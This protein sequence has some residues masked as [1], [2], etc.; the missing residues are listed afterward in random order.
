METKI[1]NYHKF[2]IS[3]FIKFLLLP[4]V[5]TTLQ[6]GSALASTYNELNYADNVVSYSQGYGVGP[7]YSNTL[8]AL[9]EEDGAYVSLGNTG[10]LIVEFTDNVLVGDGTAAWDLAILDVGA[11]DDIHVYIST[12][13]SSWLYIGYGSID[14][15]QH[16]NIDSAQDFDAGALYKYVKIVDNGLEVTTGY[17]SAGYDVDAVAAINFTAAPVP[18]PAAGWL[19]GSCLLGVAGIRKFRKR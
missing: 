3:G 17:P 14:G 11:A 4:I 1:N 15:W 18:I 9:G 6:M 7:G 19:F 8:N 13:L 2:S 12:D 10:K 5:F 16:Y